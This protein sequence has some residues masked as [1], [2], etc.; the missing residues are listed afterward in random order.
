ME[1]TIQVNWN[2]RQGKE[3]TG[4]RFSRKVTDVGDMCIES[5]GR[6]RATG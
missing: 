6:D 1:A 5:K 2:L 3:E 4:I